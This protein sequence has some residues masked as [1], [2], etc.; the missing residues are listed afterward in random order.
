MHGGK[1]A[2]ARG[3]AKASLRTTER[4]TRKSRTKATDK[5][6]KIRPWPPHTTRAQKNQAT[7][8]PQSNS[9]DCQLQFLYEICS[10]VCDGKATGRRWEENRHCWDTGVNSSTT[11]TAMHGGKAGARRAAK[12]SPRTTERTMSKRRTKATDKRNKQPSPG[13]QIRR[14]RAETTS[15][16][17]AT[18]GA[19]SCSSHLKLAVRCATGKPREADAKATC[20]AGQP[21]WSPTRLAC[22]LRCTAGRQREPAGPQRPV[23]RLTK[24]AITMKQLEQRSTGHNLFK[25]KFPGQRQ[26]LCAHRLQNECL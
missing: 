16:P 24:K 15:R 25:H 26:T 11:R 2:G 8:R 20:T 21:V 19:A 12:A 22:I 18:P 1:A 23:P 3:A 10:A 9:L 6:G 7:S 14:A 4:N 17:R 13:H 5:Q